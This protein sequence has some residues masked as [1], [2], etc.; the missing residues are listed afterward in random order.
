MWDFFSPTL[1]TLQLFFLTLPPSLFFN[2]Q[3]Y[4]RELLFRTSNLFVMQR[5]KKNTAANIVLKKLNNSQ[6]IK[7]GQPDQN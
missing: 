5:I 2:L 7:Q 3:P 1:P 4:S 6:V